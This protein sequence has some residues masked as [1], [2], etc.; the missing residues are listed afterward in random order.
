M[1]STTAGLI[2]LAILAVVAIVILVLGRMSE[3]GHGSRT[4][5][6][7]E[8]LKAWRDAKSR[9]E[10]TL[11]LI[12]YLRALFR[13]GYYGASI[14]IFSALAAA[15]GSIFG[16]SWEILREMLCAVLRFLERLLLEDATSCLP[17]I[18]SS[19]PGDLVPGS[20]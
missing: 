19:A 13:L 4:K 15:A 11:I 17:P 3:T 9:G 5:D 14:A 12:W 10:R 7:G 16:V 8:F 18:Q 20:T 1:S 2:A 6:L